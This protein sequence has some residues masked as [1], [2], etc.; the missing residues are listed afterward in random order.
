MKNQIRLRKITPVDTENIVHWRNSPDVRKNLYIQDKLTAEQ[1]LNWLKTKVD[2]GSCVQYI[3]CEVKDGGETDIG[4]VYIKNIDNVSRK[5]E[6][7]IFIGEPEG[8]GKGYAAIA[9]KSILTVAFNELCLNRVYLTVFYDNIPA[10]LTYEK[11]GFLREGLLK[12]DFKRY[13]GYVDVICMGITA[14]RWQQH[15]A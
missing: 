2:C 14:D 9:T 15:E 1:H 8:R 11:A 6:F 7:G 5:G 12:Q 3:I 13:D 10:I 4:T